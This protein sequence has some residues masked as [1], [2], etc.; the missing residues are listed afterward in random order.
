MSSDKWKTEDENGTVWIAVR[1][2]ALPDGIPC[3]A[4][5]DDQFW[6]Y[7]DVVKGRSPNALVWIPIDMG[8]FD[9]YKKG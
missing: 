1:A 7:S 5:V 3:V 4:A 9:G 8:A 2:F 6:I